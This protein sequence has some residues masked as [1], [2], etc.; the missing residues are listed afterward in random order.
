VSWPPT[1]GEFYLELGDRDRP[2]FQG[3]VYDKVPFVKVKR[4]SKL[5]DEPSLVVERR[6]VA[7]F[8]HS[9]DMVADDG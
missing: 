1:A 9:C 6:P 8:S 7:A 2:P 3:D 5:D 4:G